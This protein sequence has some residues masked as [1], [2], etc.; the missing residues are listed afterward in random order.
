MAFDE[1]RGRTS[2]FGGS[3]FT[4]SLIGPSPQGGGTNEAPAWPAFLGGQT[5]GFLQGGGNGGDFTNFAA[6]QWANPNGAGVPGLGPDTRTS[7]A[8]GIDAALTPPAPVPAS[9][10]GP[11]GSAGSGPVGGGGGPGGPPAGG[12]GWGSGWTPGGGMQNGPPDPA[13]PGNA[14]PGRGSTPV[15]FSRRYLF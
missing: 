12:P 11:T 7:G 2:S 6:Y 15:G 5:G 10:T 4:S 9:P 14:D 13:P 1:E 8:K 3:G